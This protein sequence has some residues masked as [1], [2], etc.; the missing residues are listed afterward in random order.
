MVFQ[1]LLHG[2]SR[3]VGVRAVVE[4]AGLS[5]AE[6]FAEIVSHL[7]GLH[8]EGSETLDAGNI[9]DAS[10]LRQFVECGESGGVHPR[11]VRLRDAGGA[12]VE[13]RYEPVDERTLPHPAVSCQEA[14][15]PPHPLPQR[16]QPPALQ[17]RDGM[18]FVADVLIDEQ[19]LKQALNYHAVLDIS[20]LVLTNAKTTC[21]YGRNNGGEVESL[22]SFPKYEEMLCR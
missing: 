18:H 13:S 7:S 1:S 10:P 16:L 15:L 9:D 3:F 4:A 21:L 19:V 17:G 8:V 11:T 20:Y 2:A 6:Y 12:H 5:D 22:S 14:H